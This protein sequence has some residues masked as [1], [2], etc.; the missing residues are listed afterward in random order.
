MATA[1]SLME[2]LVCSICLDTFDDPVMLDCSH[3]FC[4]ACISH[5]W[6]DSAESLSCP[7]CRRIFPHISFKDNRILSNMAEKIRDLS[8]ARELVPKSMQSRDCLR[9]QKQPLAVFCES[10]K[11]LLCWSCSQEWE[12][13]DHS[14]LPIPVAVQT[15]KDKMTGLLFL[16][17]EK[18]DLLHQS[19]FMQGEAI[20]QIK[21]S[22]D[23]LV[24]HV[25]S[26]FTKLHQ[27]LTRKEQQLIQEVKEQEEYILFP[28]REAV[29][30]YEREICLLQQ[31]MEKL[32]ALIKEQDDIAFLK[33]LQTVSDSSVLE[34]ESPDVLTG[35]VSLGVYDDFLHF[36][37]WREMLVAFD[38][39]PEHLTLLTTPAHSD[40]VVSIDKTSV[41]HAGPQKQVL[42][43]APEALWPSLYIRSTERF[44]SGRHFWEVDVGQKTE[45]AVG[46]SIYSGERITSEKSLWKNLLT[47]DKHVLML[48][49]KKYHIESYTSTIPVSLSTS[50]TRIGVFLDYERGKVTFY[51]TDD[52]S[53]IHVALSSFS[54][55]IYASFNPGVNSV[56]NAAPLHICCYQHPSA[57]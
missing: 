26:Q 31:E 47:E 13:T 38:K 12:H 16:L 52:M 35:S 14:L 19:S 55:D 5:F 22:S 50:P 6:Q 53:V 29:L 17:K 49:N 1:T 18:S 46:V 7:Q 41:R 15:Y 25:R 27:F 23:N 44:Q 3:N 11:Q 28:M 48:K 57:S 9:H 30:K 33:D 24:Q 32:Q 4:R 39:V 56:Q 51:N 2:E 10:D 37:V 43:G 36:A 45:W 8:V 42:S 54:G 34:L 21:N 40:L 20:E